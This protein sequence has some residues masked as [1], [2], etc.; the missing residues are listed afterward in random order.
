MPPP[1]ATSR[2]PPLLP[3]A[4]Q[5]TT[6]SRAPPLLP[7]TPQ[8]TAGLPVPEQQQA[9]ALAAC[10][11]EAK[12][13]V[14]SCGR[15]LKPAFSWLGDTGPSLHLCVDV[16]NQNRGAR[17]QVQSKQGCMCECKVHASRGGCVV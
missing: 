13:R 4:P 2:P 11:C 9:W 16:S 1:P 5:L 12:E 6:A 15:C 14:H 8:L 7:R 3:L 10:L 17:V